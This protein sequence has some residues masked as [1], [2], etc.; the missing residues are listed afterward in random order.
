MEMEQADHLDRMLKAPTLAAVTGDPEFVAMTAL[1]G[2]V[3]SALGGA[4]TTAADRTRI[5]LSATSK[6]IRPER[7]SLVTRVSQ[8]VLTH[9]KSM[10]AGGAAL[11]LSAAVGWAILHRHRHAAA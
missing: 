3:S 8:P 11:T 2:E 10:L 1:A 9:R 5:W 7:P 6:P 4:W